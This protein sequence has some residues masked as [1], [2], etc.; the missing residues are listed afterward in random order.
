MKFYRLPYVPIRYMR[1]SSAGYTLAEVI[2]V[3]A[4][5]GLMVG[6]TLPSLSFG[7][8]AVLAAQA[9]SLRTF[10]WYAQQAAIASGTKKLAVFDAEH[11]TYACGHQA[12]H[13][14]QGM[15]F[16]VL[17]GV[18]GPPASPTRLIKDPI[19]TIDR[20]TFS[21]FPAGAAQAGSVYLVDRAAHLMY[22]V[23]VGVASTCSVRVYQNN[24]RTT[25][26]LIA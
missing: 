9:R 4:L 8:R 26:A 15:A 6:L 18:Y 25:W 1:A 3:L 19:T 20:R 24:G 23:T 10:F 7:R 5:C 12:G 13:L 16:G 2:L 21:F 11:G 17:P 22:G 14:A